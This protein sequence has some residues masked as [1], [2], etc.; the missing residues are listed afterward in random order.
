MVLLLL[1]QMGD[2]EESIEDMLTKL[3]EYCGLVDIVSRFFFKFICLSVLSV[4]LSW[5]PKGNM[6]AYQRPG[7]AVLS[8]VKP[9]FQNKTPF[10]FQLGVFLW[11]S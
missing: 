9:C 8:W 2:F 1:L 6:S 11:S 3:D 10:S 7:H 4:F 5:L